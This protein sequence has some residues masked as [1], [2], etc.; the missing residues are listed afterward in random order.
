M[1]WAVPPVDGLPWAVPV[2]G[3]LF[4]L[5]VGVGPMVLSWWHRRHKR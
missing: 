4:V 5:L 3:L 2:G 1:T